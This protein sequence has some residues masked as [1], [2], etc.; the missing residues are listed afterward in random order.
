MRNGFYPF[1]TVNLDGTESLWFF[2]KIPQI[3]TVAK[4]HIL[5][6]ER[7]VKSLLALKNKFQEIGHIF[8]R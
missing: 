3:S 4:L 7:Q 6:N 5:T 1:W 2:E 8:L